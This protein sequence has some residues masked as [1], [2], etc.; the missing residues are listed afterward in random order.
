MICFHLSVLLYFCVSCTFI[1]LFLLHVLV[2]TMKW[3]FVSYILLVSEKQTFEKLGYLDLT[4]I[5]INITLQ[6]RSFHFNPH[7]PT[8][9][10]YNMLFLHFRVYYAVYT[11][12]HFHQDTE[13]RREEEDLSLGAMTS[14]SSSLL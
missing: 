5:I 3:L 11:T 12:V 9:T 6:G 14:S 7:T 2:Y 1:Q 4:F 8:S 10:S 13:C